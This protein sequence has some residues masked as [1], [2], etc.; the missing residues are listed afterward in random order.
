MQGM[1]QTVDRYDS[2]AFKLW[3]WMKGDHFTPGKQYVKYLA[4]SILELSRQ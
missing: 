3:Q 1:M 2:S 4:V